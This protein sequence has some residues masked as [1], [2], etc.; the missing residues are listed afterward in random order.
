VTSRIIVGDCRAV[1]A[2]MEPNSVQAIVCDPPYELK[3]M[4]KGWDGTGVAFDP[5]TWE[6]CKRVLHSRGLFAGLRRH[7]NESPD[8]VRD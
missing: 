4:G 8:G 7:E 3:F 5:A 1:M 2:E 6:A